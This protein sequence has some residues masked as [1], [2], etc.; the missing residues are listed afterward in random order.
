MS[1]VPSITVTR[2]YK[3][4]PDACVRAIHL[5]LK[6]PVRKKAAEHAPEPDGRDGT[7]AKGDSADVSILPH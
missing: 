6:N 3:N 5:L 4:S 2:A 1:G 7:K